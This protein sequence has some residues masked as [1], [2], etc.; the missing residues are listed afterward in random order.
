MVELRYMKNTRGFVVPLLLAIIGLLLVG[1]GIYVYQQQSKNPTI[2]MN[3]VATTTLQTGNTNPTSTQTPLP[4]ASQNP[5]MS[6]TYANA[7]Y[8]FNLDFPKASPAQTIGYR[9]LH[10]FDTNPI[11]YSKYWITVNVSDKASDVANCVVPGK[12]HNVFDYSEY[13]LD[14]TYNKNINGVD[15]AVSDWDSGDSYE[16]NYTT[17]HGGKCFDI[18]IITVPSCSLCTSGRPTLESYKPQ[19]DAMDKSVQTFKFIDPSSVKTPV[20]QVDGMSKY[21]EPSFG[22]SFWY[23]SGWQVTKGRSGSSPD[24]APYIRVVAPPFSSLAAVDISLTEDLG[25][26]TYA[27][28]PT[29]NTSSMG[30]LSIKAY[31]APSFPDWFSISWGSPVKSLDVSGRGNMLPLLRTILATDPS[32]ATP[33]SAVQQTAII[34]AEKDAYAGL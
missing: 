15:F 1:G 2:D 23:P 9:S 29:S 14:A 5:S 28:Q 20:V 12:I 19:L 11:V 22:F 27:Y 4:G 24:S 10:P 8:G 6:Q 17:L 33:V 16:R 3:S 21:T 7:Q 18:Q 25:P 30:G 34:Q 13:K 26:A 31:Q 32:V